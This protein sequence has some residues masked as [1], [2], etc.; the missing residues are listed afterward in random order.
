MIE[1]AT[2]FQLTSLV[3]LDLARNRL[4]DTHFWAG[5]FLHLVNVQM[6]SMA[7]NEFVNLDQ[8]ALVLFKNNKRLHALYVTLGATPSYHP[9]LPLVVTTA[10]P[11]QTALVLCNN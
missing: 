11:D 2:F 4:D 10:V 1:R 9:W 7:S 6:L 5:S 3:H 8:M